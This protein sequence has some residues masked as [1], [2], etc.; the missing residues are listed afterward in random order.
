MP[1]GRYYG[2]LVCPPFPY[3]AVNTYKGPLFLCPAFYHPS[4]SNDILAPR[5]IA[6]NGVASVISWIPN[7]LKLNPLAV[8]LEGRSKSGFQC[9]RY[10]RDRCVEGRVE[11]FAAI[12]GDLALS[13]IKVRTLWTLTSYHGC[14]Y[15]TAQSVLCC[16][17]SAFALVSSVLSHARDRDKVR[18]P[19]AELSDRLQS[20]TIA[21]HRQ[22]PSPRALILR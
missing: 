13:S 2:G 1:T 11:F 14:L 9:R 4:R 15:C 17:T 7:F 22:F 5:Y 3:L 16:R 12:D 8:S 18:L 20:F 10:T 19:L 21:L 6:I